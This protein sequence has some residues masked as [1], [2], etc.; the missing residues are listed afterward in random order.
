MRVTVCAGVSG[1]QALTILKKLVCTDGGCSSLQRREAAQ[2][3]RLVIMSATFN[4]EIFASYFAHQMVLSGAAARAAADSAGG[5]PQVLAPVLNV[6]SKCHPVATY[7]YD[8]LQ[9]L[10]EM[11]PLKE[12]DIPEDVRSRLRL[13]RRAPLPASPV[14]PRCRRDGVLPWRR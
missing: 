13:L 3:L 7:H 8:D 6:G 9:F 1:W 12:V 14:I 10:P 5:A 11:P 4:S 2:P